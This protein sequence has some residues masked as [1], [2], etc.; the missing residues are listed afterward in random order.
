MKPHYSN[1][2]SSAEVVKTTIAGADG[3]LELVRVWT[4]PE[5]RR[6][7]YATE[8]MQSL[9]ADADREGRV[10]M[11][12]PKPFGQVAGL[13]DLAR[14]Y[15]RFGFVVI[16]QTPRLMARRPQVAVQPEIASEVERG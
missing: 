2:H 5:A 7:G 3:V 6:Q 13:V 4:D 12:N 16:Q 15:E 11:L 1:E 9:C 14:W 10:L 8:L